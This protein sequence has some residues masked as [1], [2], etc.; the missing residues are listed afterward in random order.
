VSVDST[1]VK[2]FAVAN[3]LPHCVVVAL[4]K[5]DPEI[6]GSGPSSQVAIQSILMSCTITEEV[7]PRSISVT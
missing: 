3:L 7:D 6:R 1:V 4:P 5:L 2:S